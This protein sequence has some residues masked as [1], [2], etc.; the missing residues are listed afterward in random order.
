MYVSNGDEPEPPKQFLPAGANASGLIVNDGVAY[1]STSHG[2]GGADNGVYALDLASRKVTSWKSN[3]GSVAGD[4]GVSMSPDAIIYAATDGGE[5]VALESKTLEM[6]DAYKAGSGFTASPVIFPFK[7]KTLLAALSKDGAVHVLDAD[8]IKQALT[9]SAANS[10]AAN[11][12]AGALSTWQDSAGT[13]WLL[14]PGKSGIV[15]WKVTDDNGKPKLQAGWTSREMVSPLSPM[16]LNG[17]VFAVA[18]GNRSTNAIL[19]AL[20]PETGKELW[21]SGKSITSFVHNGNLSA[22]GSQIYLG[23][24]DGNFYAFGIWI[25]H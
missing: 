22:G 6:K 11:P 3:S 4:S 21:S 5:I 8:D 10:A 16:I 9:K 20:D 15:A 18:G 25:E 23:T 19:Y 7:D 17:V 24:H 14:A 12:E 13:R 2:C 1:V